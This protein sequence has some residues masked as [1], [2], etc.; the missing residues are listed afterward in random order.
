MGTPKKY[1]VTQR[2]QSYASEQSFRCIVEKLK[3]VESASL[4]F[5]YWTERRS[6]F[7]WKFGKA[8][9]NYREK[10][11]RIFT[12]QHSLTSCVAQVS[13][14]HVLNRKLSFKNMKGFV[15]VKLIV[16]YYLRVYGSRLN[17]RVMH[18]VNHVSRNIFVITWLRHCL[19]IAWPIYTP[20]TR[21][22][23]D[24]T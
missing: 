23:V 20:W 5:S 14:S 24:L 15:W 4:V 7:A 21:N 9:T 2:V 10:K 18:F 17:A 19:W 22:E 12:G 11:E 1:I 16:V 13:Q 8:L 6:F 3:L